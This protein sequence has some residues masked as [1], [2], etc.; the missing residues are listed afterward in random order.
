MALQSVKVDSSRIYIDE[1]KEDSIVDVKVY[2]TLDN[3]RSFG[4]VVPVTVR[5]VRP[6]TNL[7]EIQESAL[8]E[9]AEI[10]H[11]AADKVMS[12]NANRV[13]PETEIQ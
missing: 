10:L 4:A 11:N 9:T 12:E 7:E 6:N 5:K 2:V 3:R 1:I 13:A 8:K